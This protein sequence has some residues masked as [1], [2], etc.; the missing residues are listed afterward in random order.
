[1]LYTVTTL[2]NRVRL[3]TAL[4][5]ILANIYIATDSGVDTSVENKFPGSDVKVGSSASGAGDNREIPVEEG[6]DLN[7][8]TGQ[9]VIP[10][11]RVELSYMLTFRQAY[12][13]SRLRGCGWTRD[14]ASTVRRGKS[15]QR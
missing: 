12:K 4:K 7:K 14:K 15:G 2:V 6:G 9:Q 11:L 10:L 3:P 1:M 8:A 5:E 13:G